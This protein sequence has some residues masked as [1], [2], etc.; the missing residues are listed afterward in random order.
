MKK[1]FTSSATQERLTAS[2]ARADAAEKRAEQAER[3]QCEAEQTLR[4][5]QFRLATAEQQLQQL[6]QA[7]KKE[8][9]SQQQRQARADSA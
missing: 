1:L 8:Q 7:W 9:A 5:T 4:D 3:A 2:E 6:I